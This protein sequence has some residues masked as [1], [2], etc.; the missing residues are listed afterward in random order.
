MPKAHG[1]DKAFPDQGMVKL[2]SEPSYV[3]IWMIGHCRYKLLIFDIFLL[4][5]I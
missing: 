4:L 2:S 5:D 1:Y 3:C